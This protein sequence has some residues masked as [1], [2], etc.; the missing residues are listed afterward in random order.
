MKSL[1]ALL[2]LLA[3]VAPH[4]AS[5]RVGGDHGNPG[6]TVVREFTLTAQDV[7]NRMK[8]LP[9][10][11]L[12]G[13]DM[14]KLQ[15]AILNVEVESRDV[16]LTDPEDGEE[17]PAMN[18]PS[19]NKIVVSTTWWSRLRRAEETEN[20]LSIVLHEY[21]GIIGVEYKDFNITNRIIPLILPKG[22]GFNTGRFWNPLNPINRIMT[23][24]IYNPAG[25]GCVLNGLDFDTQEQEEERTEETTGN[26]G[27]AYRKVTVLKSHYQAP[28]SSTW[29]GL[30]HRFEIQVYDD[31]GTRLGETI[32]EPEWGRCLLPTDGACQIGGKFFVGGVEFTM[33]FRR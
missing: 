29:Q 11:E 18:F 33:W 25:N 15:G 8:L 3:F 5:A 22:D 32:V 12:V 16:P 9:S 10:S 6:N 14:N 13:I 17:K 23:S 1:Y 26:C 30:V 31:R 7:F 27:D 21:L 28:P 19:R 2:T 24:L 20:R 4:V